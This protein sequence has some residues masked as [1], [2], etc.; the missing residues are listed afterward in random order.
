MTPVIKAL[1]ACTRPG[2]HFSLI[3]DMELSLG[4]VTAHTSDE[5]LEIDACLAARL[6]PNLYPPLE[7]GSDCIDCGPRRYG[8][9]GGPPPPPPRG[10]RIRMPLSVDRRGE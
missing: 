7:I 4:K 8:V 9:F 6:G 3:V 5:N 1:C 2:S 10:A